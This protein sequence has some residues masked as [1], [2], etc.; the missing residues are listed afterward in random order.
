MRRGGPQ[1]A[2]A[3]DSMESPAMPPETGVRPQIACKPLYNLDSHLRNDTQLNLD[4]FPAQELN[5]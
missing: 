3:R 5:P 2:A 4:G 1:A